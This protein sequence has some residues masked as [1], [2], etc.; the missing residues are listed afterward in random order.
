[1]ERMC[2]NCGKPISTGSI[3]RSDV[4]P[5]CGKDMRVCKNCRFYA[6]GMHHDCSETSADFVKDKERSTFCDYFS[7]K[8]RSEPAGSVQKTPSK[9][10]S[11]RNAFNSLFGD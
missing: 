7:V 11:A 5:V 9:N 1:M 8:Q 6:P 2:W 4:C 3:V 10:D